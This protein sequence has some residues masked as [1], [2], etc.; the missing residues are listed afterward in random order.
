MKVAIVG[1]GMAGARIARELGRRGVDVTV[2][3]AEPSAAYNRILLS[4]MIAGKQT[5]AEIALPVPP[6]H[7]ELRLG[8]AVE[9]VDLDAKTVDGTPFDK[10]VLATGAEAFVP[11]VPGLDP[12]PPGP[13]SCAPSRTPGPSS[14]RPRTAPAPSSSE[15]GSSAWRPR[16]AWPGAAWTSPSSTPAA[17]SWTA[18]STPSARGS[19]RTRTPSSGSPR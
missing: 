16:G 14:T 2:F 12:S 4:S 13:T 19:S 1:Y 11:P 15:A 8:E 7:V 5:E 6:D 10:L 18:S 9:S 3:G 17:T